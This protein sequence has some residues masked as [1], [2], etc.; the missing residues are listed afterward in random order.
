MIVTVN[1]SDVEVVEPKIGFSGAPAMALPVIV[2]VLLLFATPD[3]EL[4][5][6]IVADWP[7]A[8]P[9]TV[10]SRVLPTV[11]VI[12]TLPALTVGDSQA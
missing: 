1:P 7:M 3:N 8:N 12:A 11:E 9:V 6:E 2:L 4:V 5:C 10:K